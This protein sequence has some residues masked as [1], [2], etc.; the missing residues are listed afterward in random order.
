[1]ASLGN[2]VRHYSTSAP[3]LILVALL[4]IANVINIGADLGAMLLRT[5]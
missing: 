4:F 3:T 1:M 2:R 5:P